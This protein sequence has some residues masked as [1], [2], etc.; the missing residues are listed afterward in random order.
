MATTFVNFEGIISHR[1]KRKVFLL[2]YL[3]YDV[4]LSSRILYYMSRLMTKPTRTAKTQISLGVRPVWSVSSLSA[5]RTLGSLATHWVDSEDSDQTG[6][7]PKLVWIFAG[8]TCMSFCWFGHEMSHV[9]RNPVYAICEQ[10]R[11]RSACASAQS[12][13]H[14]CCSLPG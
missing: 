1:R 12:D 13:Q 8:R 2:I 3:T 9:I 5:W 7:M 6:R 11:C 4:V 10:Q 14:L